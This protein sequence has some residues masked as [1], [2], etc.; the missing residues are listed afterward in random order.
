MVIKKLSDVFEAYPKSTA[1]FMRERGQCFYIPAYQRPFSWG[2][3][4]IERLVDDIVHGLDQLLQRN[5]AT[6]FIGTLITIHDTAYTTIDPLVRAQVPSK[7]MTVIDGQQRLTTLLLVNMVLHDELANRHTS[8]NKPSDEASVW[9]YQQCLQTQSELLDTLEEDMSHGDGHFQWYPR[10]AR[11]YLDKWSRLK[12]EAQYKSDI[13]GLLHQYGKHRRSDNPGVFKP[14]STRS[15]SRSYDLVRRMLRRAIAQATHQDIDFPDVASFGETG[16]LALTLF[17]DELPTPV[18]EALE[19]APTDGCAE[20]FRLLVFGRFALHRVA[21]TVVTARSEDYAFD[22]FES[23]NTT[24]EPLTAFETFRPRVI[25]EEGHSEYQKST[26]HGH[27]GK[28]EAYLE[29]F[30]K[31]QSRLAATSNLLIPFA[32][33]ES[34]YKLS[35]RLSDQRRY[36]RSTYDSHE[37]SERDVFLSN[38]GHTAQLLEGAWDKATWASSGPSLTGLEPLDTQEK[39][40]FD[41][42]QSTNHRIAIGVLTRFYSAQRN[43]DE[44]N[45]GTVLRAVTAFLALW[46]GAKGGTSGIDAAHRDLLSKGRQDAA[47]PALARLLA[48]GVSLDAESVCEYF[49]LALQDEGLGGREA[50]VAAAS[51]I[52]IYQHNKDLARLLLLAATNDTTVD[53][54]QPGLIKSARSGVLPLLNYEKWTD[55]GSVTVE[56]IAPQNPGDGSKWSQSIYRDTGMKDCLGNLLLLPARANSLISNRPWTEKRLMYKILVA[57]NREEIEAARQGAK[58][59]GLDVAMDVLVDN[60]YLPIVAGVAAF[61]S[62]WDA[63]IISQRSRLLSGLAWD[64]LSPW[65]YAPS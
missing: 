6:T 12:H 7:V 54:A 33:A 38:M 53:P 9:L 47:I 60:E 34:G 50:W 32:L 56:H 58:D 19:S 22:M 3:E 43:G 13:A 30:E 4:N 49:R 27:L 63:E 26:A 23:L 21:V 45:I 65:L 57:R 29:Q 44:V 10:M 37:K 24:G 48:G 17:N 31:A 14:D 55:I 28:V 62:D 11:A 5:D 52:P 39:L 25:R 8:F 42:L 41:V 36:L 16:Y 61:S 64:R 18:S 15:I 20:L 46:R 59:A 1:D 40:C 51:S 35:K 2:R